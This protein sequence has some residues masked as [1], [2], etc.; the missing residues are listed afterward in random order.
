MI[1]IHCPKCD[2]PLNADDSRAGT[3]VRC[4]KCGH[5]LRL[6]VG[7][8]GSTSDRPEARGPAA[9]SSARPGGAARKKP[10]REDEEEVGTDFEMVE[11]EAPRTRGKQRPT[12]RADEN[13][14]PPRPRDDGAEVEAEETRTR[15]SRKKRKN[16]QSL[17]GRNTLF[18]LV[19]IDVGASLLL[20]VLILTGT[21]L[22]YALV[23]PPLAVL[24]KVRLFMLGA[25]VLGTLVLVRGALGAALGF[26]AYLGHDAAR[27][28]HALLLLAWAALAG[29][30]FILG[31]VDMI[32]F[33]SVI[34]IT[35]QGI[36]YLLLALLWQ[37][38]HAALGFQFL[39]NPDLL[40]YTTGQG[41]EP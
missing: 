13:K 20:G 41:E 23:S 25:G 38:G 15:R 2:A 29:L 9:Q 21:T 8:G 5:G 12:D 40:K 6:P 16:R 39:W 7:K 37:A 27:F 18:T 28:L 3:T 22:G 33:A 11:E 30:G 19:G 10:R 14:P 31:V 36:M 17:P 1:R 34:G 32:R 26:V 35:A 24:L 4:P